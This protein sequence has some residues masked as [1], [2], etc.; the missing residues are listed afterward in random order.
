MEIKLGPSML[1]EYTNTAR[2]LFGDCKI[3]R[4]TINKNH[5]VVVVEV[6][7]QTEVFSVAANNPRKVI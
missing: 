2:R 3:K 1:E 5:H 6:D 7:T 4:I